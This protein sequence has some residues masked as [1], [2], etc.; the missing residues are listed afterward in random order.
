MTH[1]DL[2]CPDPGNMS[3]TEAVLRGVVGMGLIEAILVI[4]SLSEAY[5]A[6]LVSISIYTVLTAI[7]RLDPFYAL[8]G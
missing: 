3:T 7:M 1:Q 4:P 2:P 8:I 5:L 6:V